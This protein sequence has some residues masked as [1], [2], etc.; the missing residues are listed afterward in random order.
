MLVPKDPKRM[1]KSFDDD[2]DNGD[3]DDMEE[4]ERKIRYKIVQ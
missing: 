1:S 2:D 4:L 3:E